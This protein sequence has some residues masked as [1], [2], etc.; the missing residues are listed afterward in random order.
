V[1]KK[2]DVW[3]INETGCK[4]IERNG[5]AIKAV[6]GYDRETNGL[7]GKIGGVVV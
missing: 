4:S 7:K 3:L 6:D 5:W 1:D 2:K